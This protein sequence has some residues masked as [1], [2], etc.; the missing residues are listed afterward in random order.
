MRPLV[1]FAILTVLAY[2]A[3]AQAPALSTADEKTIYSAA[4]RNYDFFEHWTPPM[5]GIL[6]VRLLADTFPEH[7]LPTLPRIKFTLIS[8]EEVE[9]RRHS[10]EGV[11][12][13]KFHNVKLYR[14]RAELEMFC[15]SLAEGYA[16]NSTATFVFRKVRGKWDLRAFGI[17]SVVP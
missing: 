3:N 5:S 11:E 8:E 16:A 7:A 2:K 10:K 13:C 9:R 14:R 12:Y 4:L 17:G 6:E 15:E 1:F